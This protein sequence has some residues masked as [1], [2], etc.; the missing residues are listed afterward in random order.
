LDL[1]EVIEAVFN[2]VMNTLDNLDGGKLLKGIF[3]IIRK[4]FVVFI[5]FISKGNK[6]LFI[7]TDFFKKG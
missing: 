1:T 6:V 2:V 3:P 7:F 4:V 5:V